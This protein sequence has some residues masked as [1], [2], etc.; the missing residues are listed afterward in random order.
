MT[1]GHRNGG[2]RAAAQSTPAQRANL[3]KKELEQLVVEAKKLGLGLRRR[4]PGAGHAALEPSGSGV[5]HEV[6]V[7]RTIDLSKRFRKTVVLDGLNL[8]VPEGS[9]YGLVGTN[10]AGKTTTIK[11]LMNLLQPIGRARGSLWTRFAAAGAA[12]DFTQ[13]GYVSENQEMPD[14]MTVGDFMDYLRPFYPN[15]DASRAAELLLQ[16][17]LPLD[18]KLRH[19]SHGMRMKAAL[20]SSLAYSTAP[21]SARRAV[22]RPRSAGARR[23]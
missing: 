23:S 2:R 19:L 12:Q 18:R 20:A 7:L 6:D 9:V 14:W 11:I 15:W 10:G 4:D 3:L 17:D 22:H 13:I 21:D 16:F 1:P 8:A 5:R